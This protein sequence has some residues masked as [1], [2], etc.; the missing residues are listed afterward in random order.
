MT[1]I[2]GNAY[3][4]ITTGQLKHRAKITRID[5]CPDNFTSP[6]V[7]SRLE[8]Y[9]GPGCPVVAEGVPLIY[10][11]SH[12]YYNLIGTV[13]GVFVG[14]VVSL[15][16]QT[17]ESPSTQDTQTPKF[18][19]DRR[20]FSPLVHRWLPPSTVTVAEEFTLINYPEVNTKVVDD[21]IPPKCDIDK[22]E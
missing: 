5:M 4:Y 7:L 3:F 16:T 20:L 15:L 12:M 6:E 13:V 9:Q 19:H 1:W 18:T 21:E 2:I 8:T 14:L 10:Q 22:P 11:V 17:P